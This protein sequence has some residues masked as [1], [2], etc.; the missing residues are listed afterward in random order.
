MD[1]SRRE[2]TIAQEKD[3]GRVRHVVEAN[4]SALIARVASPHHPAAAHLFSHGL[5][6]VVTVTAPTEL[7]RELDHATRRP[8]R[9]DRRLPSGSRRGR[10]VHG[11]GFVEKVDRAPYRQEAHLG[12]Y[13]LASGGPMSRM[14]RRKRSRVVRAALLSRFA[15]AAC[16]SAMMSFAA[17]IRAA[18]GVDPFVLGI[19]VRAPSSRSRSSRR[20]VSTIALYAEWTCS[21]WRRNWGVFIRHRSARGDEPFDSRRSSLTHFATRQRTCPGSPR[22]VRRKPSATAIDPAASSAG[23]ARAGDERGRATEADGRPRLTAGASPSTACPTEERPSRSMSPRARVPIRRCR[24]SARP[25]GTR[26]CAE[27]PSTSGA[28]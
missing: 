20:S 10:D 26:A 14:K 15:A 21:R 22:K 13:G 27:C 9:M 24:S 6:Q 25:V 18:L 3:V 4:S 1:P 7:R 23:A 28:C 12:F 8:S 17:A 5:L 2:S 11:L 16:S 19:H